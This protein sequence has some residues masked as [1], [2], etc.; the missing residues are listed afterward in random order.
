M[1]KRNKPYPIL[2]E[3]DSGC[4]TVAEPAVA[5]A[6]TTEQAIPDNVA[7]ARIENGVLQVTPDIEE[8]IAD[9]DRGEVVAMGEFKT[10][11]AKWL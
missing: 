1:T 7:Y 9:A 4:L 2:D 8:E 6:A 3:E 11:F 10:M 5:M